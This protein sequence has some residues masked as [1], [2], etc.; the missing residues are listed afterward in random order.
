[1]S[2]LKWIDNANYLIEVMFNVLKELGCDEAALILWDV[3]ECG[4]VAHVVD[5]VGP[6][7][8]LQTNLQKY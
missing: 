3:I 8:C 2:F 1:M 4:F 6:D 5:R 7:V